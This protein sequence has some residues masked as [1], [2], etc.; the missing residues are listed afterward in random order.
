M[1]NY[2]TGILVGFTLLYTAFPSYVSAVQLY[3]FDAEYQAYYDTQKVGKAHFQVKKLEQDRFKVLYESNVSKFFLSDKRSEKSIFEVEE[4]QLIPHSY[5]YKRSGTGRNKELEVTFDNDQNR[6]WVNG[7]DTF[8]WQGELD[9]QLF[10]L[11]LSLKLSQSLEDITYDFI[12]TR[13]ERR[14]YK[15][16]VMGEEIVKLP[17]GNL[18]AI[19]VKLARES[20]KRVTYA[21]FSPDL[22][23]T[24]VRLQQFK[25]GN[26]QGD[27]QLHKYTPHYKLTRNE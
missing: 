10:R 5:S 21:W 12:N 20:N 22:N 8:D 2:K 4:S 3:E 1:K 7:V 17:Y 15:I 18:N 25:N 11:D 9:N 16:N 26:E 24:L 19:K 23:W 6:I 13:G 27:I 14:Q